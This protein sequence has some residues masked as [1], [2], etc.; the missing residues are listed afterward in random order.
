[1]GDK[2]SACRA[3]VGKLKGRRPLGTTKR[4][5]KDNIKINLREMAWTR[6]TWLRIWTGGGLL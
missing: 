1:M 5:W 3:L 6:S 4:G 2:R